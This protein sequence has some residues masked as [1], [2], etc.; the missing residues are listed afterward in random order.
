MPRHLPGPRHRTLRNRADARRRFAATVEGMLASAAAVAGASLLA[1]FAAGGS[2]ALW[3]DSAT[4]GGGTITAGSTG[5]TVEGLSQYTIP[6]AYWSDLLPGDEVATELRLENTG[7]V[8]GE[9]AAVLPASTDP[10]VVRLAAGD[11][12]AAAPGSSGPSVP[13]GPLAAGAET[14]V[15][16]RVGLPVSAPAGTQG[17]EVGIRIDLSLETGS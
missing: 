4:I 17:R 14:T 10:L 5:L 7:T 8:A 16:L 3:S 11:C 6:A 9:L 12:A 2:Y 15:C 1:V 13:L